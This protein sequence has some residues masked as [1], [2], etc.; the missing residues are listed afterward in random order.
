M[1]RYCSFESS[2]KSVYV[3]TVVYFDVDCSGLGIRLILLTLMQ[4]SVTYQ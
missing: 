4:H 1:D 2:N 3:V